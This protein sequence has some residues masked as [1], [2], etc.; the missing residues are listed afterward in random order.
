[1]D[2]QWWPFA[3]LTWPWH[4]TGLYS[5]ERNAVQNSYG[6]YLDALSAP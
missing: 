5:P 1:M 6:L 2:H 3:W 4:G